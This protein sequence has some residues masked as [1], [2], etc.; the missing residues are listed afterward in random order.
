[1]TQKVAFDVLAK[2]RA[3]KT[4]RGIGDS[5]DTLSSKVRRS[6]KALGFAVAAGAALAGVAAVKFAGDSIRAASDLSETLNKTNVVFGKSS[7]GVIDWS[8]DSAKSLGMS[9]Q[10]SLAYASQ[11]GDMFTQLGQGKGKAAETSKGVIQLATDLG[12]FNNL[13]TGEVL[14]KI[15]GAMRG[16]YDAIQKIIPGLSDARVKKEALARTG[17]A[18]V[19][20]LTEEEKSMAALAIITKDGAAS[21]NDFAETSGGLAN[22]QKILSAQLE[23]TKSKIGDKLLP[24][25]TA[26]V[27]WINDKAIPGAEKLGGWL[28]DKLGPAFARLGDFIM[29]RVVPALRDFAEDMLPKLRGALDDAKDGFK[30]AEPFMSLVGDIVANVLWPGIKLLAKVALPQMGEQLKLVGTVLGKV[31][32]IGKWLWNT[33]LQPVFTGFVRVIGKVLGALGTMFSA[34]ASVPGAPKW[35]GR[36]AEGLHDAALKADALADGIKKIPN[37]KAVTVSV[38]YQSRGARG[39]ANPGGGLNAFARGTLSA[40]RGLAWVG[41]EEPELVDFRGGERVHS[42]PESRRM[43]SGRAAG[44]GGGGMSGAQFERFMR[45]LEKMEIRVTG[46]PEGQRAYLLTGGMG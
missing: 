40:P 38:L 35:I 34:L 6:G 12:S 3:S 27:T 36:T 18:S 8:N 17:K 9:Q 39:L 14:D 13:E 26:F 23:N 30:N 1:M 31:G 10:A 25:A 45:R 44:A 21:A 11:F 46:V 28:Q 4:F 41:E 5:A 19:A 43:M 29:D 22:Q 32:E 37:K 20:Q 15:S 16:E 42:G 7:K 33:V 24:V 2:D